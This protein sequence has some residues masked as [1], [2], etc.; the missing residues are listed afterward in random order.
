MRVNECERLSE[1]VFS[2]EWGQQWANFLRLKQTGIAV[3]AERTQLHM[4]KPVYFYHKTDD[5]L[6]W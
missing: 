2:G 1:S 6:E 4:I 5:V 3:Y